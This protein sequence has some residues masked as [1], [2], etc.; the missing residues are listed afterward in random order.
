MPP[1]RY[2]VA[3]KTLCARSTTLQRKK[4]QAM[5]ASNHHTLGGQE[6][7]ARR[8]V[9]L[10]GSLLD[11]PELRQR[12][13]AWLAA[14]P[15]TQTLLVAGGGRLAD[16]V[17]HA[18][19]MHALGEDQSH[20]LC[21]RAMKLNACVARVLVGGRWVRRVRRWAAKPAQPGLWLLDPWS[22]LRHEEP[23]WASEPLPHTWQVT[24]DSIAARLSALLGVPLVLLKSATPPPPFSASAL[25]AANFVDPYF[26][27]AALPVPKIICVDLRNS[28]STPLQ[29]G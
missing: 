16:A 7:V 20:W 2:V 15:G 5:P 29:A 22:F 21:V 25:A 19:A 28:T 10:G 18:D 27:Q 14:E 8:V 13:R 1:L 6:N 9:K 24:S 17:R 12:L 11:W 3:S 4:S 26:P 23:Y